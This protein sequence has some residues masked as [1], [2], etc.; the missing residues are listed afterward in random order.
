MQQTHVFAHEIRSPLTAISLALGLINA[1]SIDPSVDIYFDIIKRNL[2]QINT[3]VTDL[4]LFEE[5]AQPQKS[6]LSINQIL[7]DILE[8]AKD[9]ILLKK[10]KVDKV[11][12]K[13]FCE[14]IVNPVR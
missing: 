4:I 12:T 1:E 3:L 10:I 9:R 13:A 7:E 5:K 6:R 14:V 8:M 2:E 11:Y